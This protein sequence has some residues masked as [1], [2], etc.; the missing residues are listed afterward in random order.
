MPSASS[1][2]VVI[3][4]GGIT[5][6]SAAHE[7]AE[8][9]FDVHIVEQNQRPYHENDCDIGGV[10]RTQWTQREDFQGSFNV[11][12]SVMSG[13]RSLGKLWPTNR[14][15][16]FKP[17]TWTLRDDP[18]PWLKKLASDLLEL[19]TDTDSQWFVR[20]SAEQGHTDRDGD[21]DGVTTWYSYLTV[22]G[23]ASR[24]EELC[25]PNLDK[26]R[27]DFQQLSADPLTGKTPSQ[28]VLEKIKKELR[29]DF[30][31]LPEQMYRSMWVQNDHMLERIFSELIGRQHVL[32]PMSER[33]VYALSLMRSY[34]IVGRL[35]GVLV[36]YR[37]DDPDDGVSREVATLGA[38]ELALLRHFKLPNATIFK[39]TSP[40]IGALAGTLFR[41][42]HGTARIEPQPGDRPATVVMQPYTLLDY[43]LG[44]PLPEAIDETLRERLRERL[45]EIRVIAESCEDLDRRQKILS[46][47]VLDEEQLERLARDVVAFKECA[48]FTA[49]INSKMAQVR[50]RLELIPMAIGEAAD[51]K[52]RPLRRP[53]PPLGPPPSEPVDLL[54]LDY[55]APQQLAYAGLNFIENLMPGE[56]GYRYFPA[57]YRNLF[58]TMKRT[59]I[60]ERRAATT[61][62]EARLREWR[63][64]V[65]QTRRA[66]QR[67]RTTAIRPADVD[68]L[69]PPEY[70]ETGRSVFD[71]LLPN[72]NHAIADKDDRRPHEMTRS[73]QATTAEMLKT[74]RYMMEVRGFSV[75][76]MTSFTVKLMQYL[77]SCRQRREREHEEVSW[78][79]FLGADARSD[80][81]Q[82]LLDQWPQ[83]L[84]GLRSKEGDARS[85][86]SVTVQLMADQLAASG[87]RDGTLNG[88]TSVAWL[89]P[90]RR[91]LEARGVH[92]HHGWLSG[93]AL[94]GD[95]IKL[96]HHLHE[97]A[98]RGEHHAGGE[99]RPLSSHHE[100]LE[101]PFTPCPGTLA[102]DALVI[103]ATPL[104]DTWKL[105]HPETTPGQRQASD[106]DTLKN[107]LGQ[108]ARF[109][110]LNTESRLDKA[111]P[112]SPL[113]HYSGMQFYIDFE[114]G[115]EKG[116]V[117]YAGTP[118]RLSSI[119]QAQFWTQRN[120]SEYL[121][122]LS[123]VIGN[124]S[125]A[126]DKGQNAWSSSPSELAREVWQQ[127]TSR[128]EFRGRYIPEPRAYHIDDE[129]RFGVD[130]GRF[131]P[132]GNRTPYQINRVGDW[133]RRPGRLHE[134]GY[135]VMY[136]RLVLAGPHMKTHTR[137]VTM[138]AANESARH[139][140]NGLL[141]AYRSRSHQA[142]QRVT[143]HHCTV[144][145]IEE[146]EPGDLMLLKALDEKLLE[147]GLP[148]F[149]EI[150]EA[151]QLVSQPAWTILRA[152]GINGGPTAAAITELLKALWGR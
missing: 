95:N 60:L 89:Q 74:L 52:R 59:P 5:G 75:E 113:Q 144:F 72:S 44:D 76:D 27:T 69:L 134:D 24:W 110:P 136:G 122:V 20:R 94:D 106:F 112:D 40:C 43:P 99:L 146:H 104:L 10:A 16:A 81:Y 109:L 35:Y 26:W 131:Q 37:D 126:G 149:L 4:G 55:K 12:T 86:G 9:G 123:V 6:L 138:E 140:V 87:Y 51:P 67:A 46:L 143:V 34:V 36:S 128:L 45:R 17:G 119:S 28:Q 22:E 152:L 125:I 56:H 48:A 7:L 50:A 58:D 33:W 148:H 19:V 61:L 8:R 41:D 30:E 107:D 78:W 18:G 80:S 91:Y 62:Q 142:R 120:E 121:G 63:Q 92:F 100:P 135:E 127:L 151:E 117:Y 141:E 105:L 77:T 31:G 49:I 15:I 83:A 97:S 39:P 23:F 79:D 147:R 82:E 116:H 108:L 118:W 96:T 11:A 98:H 65:H 101:D 54:E 84:V 132:I 25:H 13:G 71:N 137:L 129:I 32:A 115:P 102:D 42:A 90:W 66:K 139:A 88:P 47:T 130:D 14:R 111:D 2:R 21:G 29:G 53:P 85:V 1:P 103:I 68:P 150:I 73:K 64:A 145:D 70:V 133:K 114:L 93:I 57:F 124:W 38:E 3:Y